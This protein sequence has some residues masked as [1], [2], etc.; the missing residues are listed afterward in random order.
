MPRNGDKASTR[1]K[2]NA[3]SKTASNQRRVSKDLRE[4]K[5]LK[6]SVTHKLDGSTEEFLPIPSA[7]APVAERRRTGYQQLFSPDIDVGNSTAPPSETSKKH[8]IVSADD[9]DHD[10]GQL[11]F[12]FEPN[13]HTADDSI[14]ST[15][16]S[17][18]TE[19]LEMEHN[20][21]GFDD[22]LMDDD[23]LDLT[24]DTLNASSNHK[25]QS[26]SP[27]KIDILDETPQQTQ[28]SGTSAN[29]IV[30]LDEE[31]NISGPPSK[32]FVS[33]VTLTTRLLA[34]TGNEARKPIVRPPFPAAVR[35]RSP[36]IGLSSNTLLRSCFRVGEAINQ[37]C[38]A[39]KTG[40]N[41]LVELYAR[42]LNSERDDLQQRF[43]FC[44]LFHTKPPYIQATYAAAIWKTVQ[45]FEYDSA[46]LLQQGTVCR[47]MGTMKRN[48]KDWAMTILN[49]WEATWDDVQWV[50]GIVKS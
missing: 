24:T 44:D 49:I 4:T 6:Q 32:T 26:S 45:L 9:G 43:T 33:P 12:D 35:D 29:A 39:V 36:I 40:N 50:E 18:L 13:A 7:T 14:R 8:P 5:Q 23:L 48:G 41:I 20:E 3:D 21:D 28:M 34:A 1:K 11:C 19:H 47:C 42:V 31:V 16:T 2:A 27:I 46:R 10:F 38:Q 17:Q 25:S 30:L 15:H 22:D 37:S